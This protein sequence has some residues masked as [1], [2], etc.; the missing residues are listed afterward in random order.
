MHKKRDV[1]NSFK[2]SALERIISQAMQL[3]IILFLARILGPEAFGIV[4]L[5]MVFISIGQVFVDG[6][7]LVSLV[8]QE[9]CSED[10]YSTAFYFNVGVGFFAFLML[11]CIAHPVAKFYND[12]KVSYMLMTLGLSLIFNSLSIVQKARLTKTL[13]FKAQAK[14]SICSVFLSGILS[15]ILA[16]NNYGAW[17]LVYQYV[18]MSFLNT[19]MLYFF[20]PWLPKGNFAKDSFKQLFGFSYKLLISGLIDSCYKNIYPV[21]IG[22]YFSS[23]QVG[24]FNQARQLSSIPAM[25]LTLIIQR[26]TFPVLSKVQ[27]NHEELD[28]NYL[29][30]LK[31][32]TATIFPVMLGISLVSD[33]LI[34]VILGKE[35][36][37]SISYLAILSFAFAFYPIHAINLNLIHVKG[38]SDLFLKLELVKKSAATVILLLSLNFGLIGI[39]IS[40]L[41]MSLFELFANTYVT[42]KLSS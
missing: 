18:L 27:K 11:V 34:W 4:A 8:R 14:A 15:I 40:L 13:D 26:V 39:C 25:T 32:A 35:W 16:F 37:E 12:S 41:I 38:R 21:I 19:S 9:S 42:Q 30:M 23:A 2:W 22:K 17:A 24:F 7:I 31:I 5:M 20:S 33:S 29:L 6:G 36:Q 3:C 1:I 10:D 28:S